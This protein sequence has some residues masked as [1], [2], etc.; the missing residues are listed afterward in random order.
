[1]THNFVG[2]AKFALLL[3]VA[4]DFR[5]SILKLRH[6]QDRVR[7][8]DPRLFMG[9]GARFYIRRGARSRTGYPC[10]AAWGAGPPRAAHMLGADLQH[11]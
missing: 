11:R 1:V 6:R 3:S 4:E 9:R 5:A 10:A 7:T 8:A 2:G